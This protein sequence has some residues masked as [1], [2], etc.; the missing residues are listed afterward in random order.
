MKIKRT[1][2]IFSY[3]SSEYEVTYPD[4]FIGTIWSPPW[5]EWDDEE[6]DRR[7]KEYAEELFSNKKHRDNTPSNESNWKYI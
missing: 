4:G 7:A 6:E 2:N 3:S 1:G 5:H